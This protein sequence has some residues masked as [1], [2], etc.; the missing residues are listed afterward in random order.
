[1]M[2]RAFIW[3]ALFV[4]AAAGSLYAWL[5]W[6]VYPMEFDWRAQADLLLEEGDC[7]TFEIVL[8]LLPYELTEDAVAYVQGSQYQTVC[9]EYAAQ[10]SEYYDRPGLEGRLR[11]F[12]PSR[13]LQPSETEGAMA[14]QL[15]DH[16]VERLRAPGDSSFLTYVMEQRFIHRC[17]RHFEGEMGHWQLIRSLAHFDEKEA[18]EAFERRA[19]ECQPYLQALVERAAQRGGDGDYAELV[20]TMY[21]IHAHYLEHYPIHAEL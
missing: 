3:G 17:A 13:P 12:I 15:A 18:Y 14:A 11:A 19:R 1:M 10:Q 20:T 8:T 6:P 7:E 21:Q 16:Q 2:K 4:L 5:V 9:P